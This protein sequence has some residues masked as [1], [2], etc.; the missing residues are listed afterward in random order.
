MY[1]DKMPYIFYAAVES[2]I[3]KI[4]RQANNP[5]KRSTTKIVEHIP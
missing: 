1:S 5:E 3:K 4:D 2:L